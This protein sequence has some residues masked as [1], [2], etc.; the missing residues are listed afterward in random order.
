MQGFALLPVFD[1]TSRGTDWNDLAQEQG[2]ETASALLA[3]GLGRTALQ[4]GGLRTERGE[5]AQQIANNRQVEKNRERELAQEQSQ[6]L[7]L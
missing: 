5:T 1:E 6:G 3:E 2:I 7:S 4:H